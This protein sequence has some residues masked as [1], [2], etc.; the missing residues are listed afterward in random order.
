VAPELPATGAV[1]LAVVTWNVHAGR[2]DLS[3]LVDDLAEGQLTNRRPVRHF[4]V[5]LQENIAGSPDDAVAVA[6]QRQVW[7]YFAPVRESRHGTSGNA[8]LT[9]LRPL[10]ARTIDLPRE[11][12]VRKAIAAQFELDGQSFFVVNAH[13]ENRTSFLKGLL[14]SDAARHRQARALL[15]ALPPGPGIVGGDLNTWLGEDEP[16]LQALG[17]RFDDAVP[18]AT[19]ATFRDKLVLDHLLFDLPPGWTA[20]RRVVPERYGSD[21]QPVIGL[22]FGNGARS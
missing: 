15:A 16:A 3:R 12:R 9:T 2:G 14:F 19:A 5:L 4:I 1:V 18:G 22:I 20:V 11:R 13:L 6:R 17:E 7:S 21:H 8:L 10:H